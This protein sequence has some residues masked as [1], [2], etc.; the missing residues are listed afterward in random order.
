ME[1]YLDTKHFVNS[2]DISEITYF[3][4]RK[5]FCPVGESECTYEFT[6][7]FKPN[8]IIPDYL[9]LDKHFNYLPREMTIEDALNEVF[10][11]F[12][13]VLRPYK[14]KVTCLCEDARHSKVEVVKEF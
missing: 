11:M 9:E 14:L 6:V 10:N 5:F 12:M 7:K 2:Q 13:E 1:R 3:N 4:S 8:Q